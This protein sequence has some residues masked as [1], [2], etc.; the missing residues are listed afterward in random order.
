VI[1]LVED[2]STVKAQNALAGYEGT[3][4]IQAVDEETLKEL[5][6]AAGAES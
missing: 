1:A 3:L 4:V 5:Y 2:W 6:M